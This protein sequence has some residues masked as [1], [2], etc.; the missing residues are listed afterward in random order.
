MP[1]K[2]FVKAVE[3]L[4]ERVPTGCMEFHSMRWEGKRLHGVPRMRWEILIECC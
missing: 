3:R 4:R 1:Q 2:G